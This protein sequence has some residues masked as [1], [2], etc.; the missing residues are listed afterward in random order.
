VWAQYEADEAGWPDYV[1][2]LEKLK[3][4][5]STIGGASVQ[6][7]NRL[8]LYLVLDHMVLLNLFGDPAA[9]QTKAAGQAG[10]RLAS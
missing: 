10:R 4:D 9:V 5:L 7:K 1:L 6:L 3:R 2:L 8:S